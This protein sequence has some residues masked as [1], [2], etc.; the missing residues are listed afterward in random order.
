MAA[1]ARFVIGCWESTVMMTVQSQRQDEP[2]GPAN[3]P[4]YK[5]IELVWPGKAMVPVRLD[6]GSWSLVDRDG[7]QR[8]Y[9]FW[10]EER[11]ASEDAVDDSLVVTGDRLAVLATL[12]RTLPHGVKMVYADLPRVVLDDQTRVFR[13]TAEQ[14]WS[15]FLSVVRAHMQALLPLLS[16]DAVVIA[17]VGDAEEPY[18]RLVLNE[19][20]G[21]TNHV[22]TIVWQRSYA[23]R[24]M[25]GMK[26]FTATH[27]PIII[28]A[29]DKQYLSP[30]ALRRLP[31]GYSL[32][33]EDPR[34][35]WKAEHKG[36]R[37]RRENS[38]FET[39][40]PPYHWRLVDGDLPPGLWRI[41]PLSGV[42][43]GTPT[44][45]GMYEF[46]VETEDSLGVTS[47]AT[48]HLDVQS[49]GETTWP[50]EV[51]W[52]VGDLPVEDVPLTVVTR[53]LPGAVVDV[54]YSAILEAKGGKPFRDKRRPGPGR[55][56]EFAFDS[57]V[58]AVLRDAVYFGRDGAAIPH[59][60]KYVRTIGGTESENQQTWWPARDLRKGKGDDEGDIVMG[61]TEDATKHLKKMVELG[62]ISELV[63]TSKPEPLLE[64]LI[65][66]F[67]N[68]GETVLEL[69]GEAAALSSV[70]VKTGRRFAYFAWQY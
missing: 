52:L 2:N 46:T 47:R 35:A 33:D 7:V 11:I 43:W 15:T 22:G 16:R 59:P 36:A 61:Y 53:D 34:G 66:L 23:P 29:V 41:S 4:S 62:L 10:P 45:P 69:F 51:P 27:D 21:P 68:P 57:L 48:F 9:A 12:S 56:W 63:T 38:D 70:A 13:G 40:L 30:V 6:D 26:E 14:T 67:S 25:R 60:K 58:K 49:S 65:Q 17:H 32:T 39:N 18:V 19:I 50:K 3:E 24:N 55:Y 20:F 37:S 31:R 54:E 44:T 28:F 5:R 42:I 1:M 64:R 8:Q